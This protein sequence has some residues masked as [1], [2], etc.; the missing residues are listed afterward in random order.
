MS[1]L[2]ANPSSGTIEKPSL[3][4]WRIVVAG[5][6]LFALFYQLGGRGLSEPDEGRFAEVGRE[7]AVTGEYLTPRL[8]GVNHLSKPPVTYWLIAL[9]VKMFGANEFAARLPAALAALGTLIAVYLLAR[10][11]R[12]EATALWTVMVLLASPLFLG[13]A[14]VITTDILLTCFVFG[15]GMRPTTGAGASSSGFTCFWD[16]GH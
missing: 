6:V 14:R 3:L 5:V 15:G 8:N 9:S 1:T 16:W 7:M 12:S 13:M 4:F 10:S 2:T 11:A